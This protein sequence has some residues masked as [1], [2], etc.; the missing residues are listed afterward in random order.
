MSAR[1][2][3]PYSCPPWAKALHFQPSSVLSLRNHAPLVP[4][5]FTSP[6][7][8]RH[9][10][11]IKRDDMNHPYAAG[12][13]V[14]K[15][16]FLLADAIAKGCDGVV[17]CGGTGSNHARATAALCAELGLKCVLV[18]RQDPYF[19]G[20][21]GNS[22]LS[23]LFGALVLLVTKQEYASVGQ[24]YLLERAVHYAISQHEMKL[25]YSIEVG[26]SSVL[27]TWGYIEAVQEMLP[28]VQAFGLEQLVFACG[29]GGTGAG[30]ALGIHLAK[31]SGRMHPDFG[32]VGYLVCDNTRYFYDLIQ[33]HLDALLGPDAAPR[34]E[35][36]LELRDDSKGLGYA[37]SSPTETALLRSVARSSG[38]LLDPCYTVKALGGLLQRPGSLSKTLFLHSGGYPSLFGTDTEQLVDHTSFV[39][40]W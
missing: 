16:E 18:L 38:V 13:K 9:D 34:A 35:S 32:L 31:K 19:T 25:P 2:L 17:T 10:M 8:N 26:G 14:R 22:L 28:E 40:N 27:G 36:L 29:S 6:N 39:T 23:S 15:L 4:W 21:A 33:R 24:H 12:N 30:L 5:A 1:A 37:L 11:Y 3:V 7:G 20:P